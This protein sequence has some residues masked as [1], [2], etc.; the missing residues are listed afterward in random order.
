MA[1]ARPR[2]LRRAAAPRAAETAPLLLPPDA[3]VERTAADRPTPMDFPSAGIAAAIEETR[4]DMVAS[5]LDFSG[6][7][8]AR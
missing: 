2:A 5:L 6:I 3:V 7:A 4:R 1:R 8:G